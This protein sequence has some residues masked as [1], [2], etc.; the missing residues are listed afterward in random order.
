MNTEN[1][2]A[3]HFFGFIISTVTIAALVAIWSSSLLLADESNEPEFP[4][5]QLDFF[6]KR[7]RP[8]LVAKC[9]ECHA[10]ASKKV[11]G[12]LLLDSRAGVLKGGDSGPAAVAN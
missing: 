9:F 8:I 11:Q 12:G 7:V 5:A 1:M 3:R 10:S 2:V 6:E 4:A